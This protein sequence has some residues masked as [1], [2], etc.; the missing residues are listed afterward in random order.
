MLQHRACMLPALA[1]RVL[2]TSLHVTLASALAVC[3]ATAGQVTNVTQCR[4]QALSHVVMLG[5]TS[6]VAPADRGTVC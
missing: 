6:G 1:V 3:P 2:C 4:I 5:R